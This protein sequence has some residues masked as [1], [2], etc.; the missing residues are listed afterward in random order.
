M[1]CHILPTCYINFQNYEIFSACKYL[2][3]SVLTAL[4]DSDQLCYEQYSLLYHF[5]G[6]AGPLRRSTGASKAKKDRRIKEE[7]YHTR[8]LGIK[9]GFSSH[10]DCKKS[11]IF[12]FTS[13]KAYES[14]H[15]TKIPA[16]GN[17]EKVNLFSS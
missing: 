2:G 3:V 5:A 13:Y 14:I 11:L 12:H 10:N 15:N 9:M 16:V 8:K 6:E 1:R 4:V 7:Y 17:S